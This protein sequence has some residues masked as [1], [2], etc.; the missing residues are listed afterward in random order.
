MFPIRFIEKPP[1]LPTQ[2]GRGLPDSLLQLEK[3]VI[4]MFGIAVNQQGL[5]GAADPSQGNGLVL[6]NRPRLNPAALC[7]LQSTTAA[8]SAPSRFVMSPSNTTAQRI[9]NGTTVCF[10]PLCFS[11]PAHNGPA[12]LYFRYSCNAIQQK[13]AGQLSGLSVCR[14]TRHMRQA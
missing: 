1:L 11:I 4:R 12:V 5:S 7:T 9:F 14:E 3:L 2:S 6:P 10:L 8:A 13:Q